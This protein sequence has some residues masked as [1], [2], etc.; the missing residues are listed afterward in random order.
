M[1]QLNDLPE[2]LLDVILEQLDINRRWDKKALIKYADSDEE[3]DEM[4][5][6]STGGHTPSRIL[7]FLVDHLHIIRHIEE[8]SLE[9]QSSGRLDIPYSAQEFIDI[10]SRLPRLKVLRLKNVIV[11]RLSPGTKLPTLQLDKLAVA[12]PTNFD[13]GG[14]L[15]V[16]G[17]F[18]TV[19]VLEITEIEFEASAF[20]PHTQPVLGQSTSIRPHTLILRDVSS[21]TPFLNALETAGVTLHVTSLSIHRIETLVELHAVCRIL[22]AI[23]ENL[24]YLDIDFD[25]A[26]EELRTEDEPSEYHC[27][28]VVIKRTLTGAPQSILTPLSI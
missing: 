14:T 17:L 11:E 12:Q 8:L 18:D 2:E 27:Y 28:T 23:C 7:Q 13:V 15:D 4:D 25:W 26:D 19:N 3:E 9:N 21:I 20:V 6:Y 5:D 10:I 24:V 1:V 16:I 22:D